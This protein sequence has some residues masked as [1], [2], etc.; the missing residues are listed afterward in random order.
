M[1]LFNH[2]YSWNIKVEELRVLWIDNLTLSSDK[3][4]KDLFHS[5]FGFIRFFHN[6]FSPNYENLSLLKLL[7]YNPNDFIKSSYTRINTKEYMW[8]FVRHC[9]FAQ[10]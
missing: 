10:P 6:L 1:G 3:S 8:I 7:W 5:Y 4:T 2:F 9:T